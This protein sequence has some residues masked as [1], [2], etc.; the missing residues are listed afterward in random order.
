M[1]S[2]SRGGKR[3]P[4]DNYPT[5]AWCIRRAIE[6][7]PLP[8]GMW[9]EPCAGTGAIIETACELRHDIEWHAIE[10]RAEC[11]RQLEQIETLSRI[12]IA[13]FLASPVTSHDH[14]SA[15]LTNP[16]YS[17]AEQFLQR[18]LDLSDHVV[19]LLRLNFLASSRR[20]GLMRTNT[21]DVYVLP[22]RPSF[23]G[24][25]TDSID[26]AWFHWQAA[27]NGRG[28]LSILPDTP[29]DERRRCWSTRAGSLKENI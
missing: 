9:L 14:F 6:A 22:N 18:A 11:S 26:Y 8:G 23:N 2:T 7:I 17:L 5:P 15:V 24:M 1:S 10:I 21:P 25:G 3:S 19:L 12:T 16:P 13:D 28:S 29:A 20:A 27:G 4:A